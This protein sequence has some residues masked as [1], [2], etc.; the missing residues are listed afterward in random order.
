[1]R[2]RAYSASHFDFDQHIEV[3]WPDASAI[4]VSEY[5][6]GEDNRLYPI[7]IHGEIRGMCESLEDAERRLSNAIAGVYPILA[8][9]GNAAV[10]DPLALASYGLDISSPQPAIFYQTPVATRWFPPG[11]RRF[12]LEATFALICAIG[13]H[14]QSALLLRAVESYR[15]ALGHWIPEQR[16]MAGE[17]LFVAAETLSRFLIESRAAVRGITPNNLARLH[18]T[19]PHVLRSRFLLDDVFGGNQPA[20]DAMNAASNGFEH[21]YMSVDDVRGLMESALEDSMQLVRRALIESS[22]LASEMSSRLLVEDYDEPRGLVP[23]IQFARGQIEATDP[24]HPPAIEM[25]A[26]DLEW[27][28]TS[29]TP[30]LRADGSVDL[31]MGAT[32]TAVS[33]PDGLK[34][35]ISGYGIRAANVV[36]KNDNSKA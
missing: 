32:M 5:T 31:S 18:N 11:G 17:F 14:P 2:V 7:T 28:E 6:G 26:I 35:D 12:D 19:N 16:L 34:I 29:I 22:G 24:A 1:M 8:L 3:T 30:K 36:A 23:A 10:A 21:G 15:R 20:M 25:G 27:S 4:F 9:A 33:I 13:Q